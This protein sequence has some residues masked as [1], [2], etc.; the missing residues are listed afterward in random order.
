MVCVYFFGAY[1]YLLFSFRDHLLSFIK[2][3]H[4]VSFEPSIL[5]LSSVESGR[6]LGVIVDDPGKDESIR[7]ETNAD[8]PWFKV[9]DLGYSG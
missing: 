9:D 6:F 7:S 2:N 4:I 5:T 1:W 3:V 8:D